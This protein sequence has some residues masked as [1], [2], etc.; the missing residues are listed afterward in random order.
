MIIKHYDLKKNIKGNINYYL[1]YGANSGLIEETINYTFL[2][3][4]SKNVFYYDENEILANINSFEE[5][6]FNQSF[7]DNDKLIIINR[8]SDKILNFI[9]EIIEKD[10]KDLKIIIKSHVLEKKSKLRNFFEKDSS[11]I[12]TPFYEDNAQALLIIAQNFFKEKNIKISSQNINFIVERSNKNR[13]NLRNELEKIANYCYKKK[14]INLEEI[15][16]LTN[17]AENYN[18]AEL[19][20]QCLARNQKRTLNI[21]NE[22]IPSSED[23]IIILKTFLYK[24]K[25]LKKLKIELQANNNTEIVISSYKPPIFWKD[26]DIIKQQLKIWSLE[27]IQSFISKINNLELL[28][29][30]NS[31]LSNQIINDFIL[32]G[33]KVSNN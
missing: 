13:I 32:E 33:L 18:I 17:L 16:K 29:K 31:Q 4:L 25:R 26:K 12:I 27:Q 10:V 9:K 1:L 20:D 28:V 8:A 15:I 14:S 30:K 3:N 24:L 21:I 11:T 2:P 22:N 7:F 23:N 6:I 5:T 19:A